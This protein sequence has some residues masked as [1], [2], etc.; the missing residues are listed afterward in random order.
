MRKLCYC[1]QKMTLDFRVLIYEG[2]IEI[3]RVPILE[4]EQCSHYEV[5]PAV[6]PDLLKLLAELRTS[7]EQGLIL[8]NE[9]NELAD[10][11]FEIYRLWD[12]T[13]LPS[14]EAVFEQKCKERIN[15]LLDVFGCAKEMND[16]QWMEDI[17]K[18]LAQISN[19]VNHS[20]FLGAN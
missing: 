6:K 1:G 5:L 8:F 17:S 9:V 2:V 11:I 13:Q 7:Q 16:E 19:Y 20:Q 18:R 12:Q 14:F 4:C 10:V 3:D 15:L